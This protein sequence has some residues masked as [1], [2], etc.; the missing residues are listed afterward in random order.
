MYAIDFHADDYAASPENSRRILALL[1]AGRIDSISVITNMSCY[2]E[3]MAMLRA[4]WS[5]FPHKPLLSLHINLI[6]GFRLSAQAKAS[7]KDRLIRETWAKLFFRGF[8]PGRKRLWEACSAEIEA[9]LRAFLAETGALRDDRGQPLPLRIDSH[10]HTHMIPLVFRALMDALERT[11]LLDHVCFIRCSAE[12]LV[13]FL[14][15]PGITGTLSPIS[16]L[17]NRMLHF[18]SLPV[19]HRL[20]AMGLDAGRIF[21]IALTGEMD[22]NRVRLALPKIKRYAQKRNA[23]LEIMVHPGRTLPAEI[24]KEYGPDDRRAFLSPK[25]DMEYEM[26]MNLSKADRNPDANLT[27]KL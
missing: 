1:E 14:W 5:R 18:L 27:G 19:R 21:G 16:L 2:A 22:L 11:G 20:H 3:C 23:Y 25:R 12:P 15:T 13:P 10:V 4:S 26:L 8:L 24:T 9:Q 7:E 17:K 6:D